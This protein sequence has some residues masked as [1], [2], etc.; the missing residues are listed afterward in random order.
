MSATPLDFDGNLNSS[1]EPIVTFDTVNAVTCHQAGI[2]EAS[3]NAAQSR[4]ILQEHCRARLTYH[5]EN[6][7]RPKTRVPRR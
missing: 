1:M 3:A 6:R 2:P 4:I 7:R 5:Y